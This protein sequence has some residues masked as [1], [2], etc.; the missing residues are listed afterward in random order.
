MIYHLQIRGLEDTHLQSLFVYMVNGTW[1]LTD[2]TREPDCKSHLYRNISPSA[3]I[4]WCQKFVTTN[5]EC[6]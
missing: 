2:S 6:L 5:I 1:H 4:S 3:Y